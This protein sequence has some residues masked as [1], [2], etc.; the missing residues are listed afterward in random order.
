M[1]NFGVMFHHFHDSEKH[2]IGQG[3]IS[4]HEFQAMI[5]HLR[6]NYDIIDADVFYT[7][8]ISRNL[9]PNQ[10]CLTFDDALA[11]QYDIAYPVLEKEKIK[12]F[13]F[14]YTSIYKGKLEKL[15]IYRHFRFKEFDSI[16]H[17]YETFFKLA[18]QRQDE[19]QC[20]IEKEMAQFDPRSYLRQSTF[21]TDNDRLFR[22]LR[23]RLLGQEKYYLLMDHMIKSFG[24]DVEANRELLWI[25]EEQLLD[26]YQSGHSI[27]LHSH[28]H[29]TAMSEKS[30]DEQ[31]RE[32][33]ENKHVI[34][35]IIKGQVYSVSYPCS[36]FNRDTDEIMRELGISIG[37]NALMSDEDHGDLHFPRLDHAYVLKEMAV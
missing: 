29:P 21:Y 32:Y 33:R 30:H 20:D 7:A 9:K 4:C 25:K 37:F 1:S 23:D 10:I 13:W 18:V 3:S 28:T 5:Q 17:F 12:A 36:S 11:C 24:Y 35:N 6:R 26:L 27:G 15:E 22:Y 34:E 19:L 8:A 31:R 16:D 14:V 2:I